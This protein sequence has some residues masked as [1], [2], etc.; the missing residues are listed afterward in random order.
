MAAT[1]LRS[2]ANKL[3]LNLMRIFINLWPP[4]LGTGI[5]ITKIAPD[6]RLIEVSMKLHW[7]NK[8][9]VGT[10]F[11]GSIYA[12]T[13]AFYMLMLMKNLGED[14]IVWDKA[15]FIDFKKPGLGKLTATFVFT[16][17]EIDAVRKQADA[18]FHYIFDKPVDVIDSDGIVIASIIKTLYV[19]NKKFIPNPQ[20]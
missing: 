1:Y 8:N 3:P 4:F 7:Y 15:A 19:R 2:F 12:M 5:K 13:D 16:Q 6:F 17:E 10:H 20:H 9:Y 14:Y 11:G 18:N